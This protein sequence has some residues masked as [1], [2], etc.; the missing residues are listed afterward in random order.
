MASKVLMILF[1]GFWAS[2]ASAA[3]SP[4]AGHR[5]AQQW[6]SSC[7]QVDASGSIQDFVPAFVT[8]ANRPD[9]SLAWVRHWL[10]DP[11]PPMAGLNLSRAQIDDVIA[12]LQTLQ[13]GASPA[14]HQIQRQN[15]P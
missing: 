12:Y 11:H 6:C 4:E 14:P 1:A 13:I 5:L 15:A 2:S 3:S 7:H 9:S 8:L 10:T